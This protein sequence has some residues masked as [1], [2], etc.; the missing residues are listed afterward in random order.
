MYPYSLGYNLKT[1]EFRRIPLD[2]IPNGYV[3]IKSACYCLNSR[4][5]LDESHY[6][7][8]G[9]LKIYDGNRELLPNWYSIRRWTD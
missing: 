5:K 4:I 2:Y 8:I 7:M 3:R 1:N 9:T 6:H